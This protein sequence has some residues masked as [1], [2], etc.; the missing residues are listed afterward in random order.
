[1]VRF[2]DGGGEGNGG[3]HRGVVEAK[4]G[5]AGGL[6]AKEPAVV[7]HGLDGGPG[8]PVAGG[9]GDGLAD[10]AVDEHSG[11]KAAGRDDIGKGPNNGRWGHGNWLFG[12]KGRG[13]GPFL[14]LVVPG[15]GIGRSEGVLR[16]YPVGNDEPVGIGIIE[17]GRQGDVAT[18]GGVKVC[19]WR[20]YEPAAGEVAGLQECVERAH[21]HSLV[22]AGNRAGGHGAKGAIELVGGKE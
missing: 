14:A 18:I 17:P 13:L 2:P 5:G 6:Q 15:L 12:G 10:D 4:D 8:F 19:R 1:M 7:N 11:A 9:E 3:D 16:G 22:A 20:G 21:E